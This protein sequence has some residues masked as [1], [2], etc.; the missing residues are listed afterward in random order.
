MGRKSDRD[1]HLMISDG[2]DCHVLLDLDSKE[3]HGDWPPDNSHDDR[4][5]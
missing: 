5:S 1:S 2:S 4:Q 3:S